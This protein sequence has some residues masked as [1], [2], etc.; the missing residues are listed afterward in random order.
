MQFEASITGKWLAMLKEIAPR[1]AR[2]ALVK[3]TKTN[4]YEH[5]MRAAEGVAPS[6]SIE[7]VSSHVEKP[8][9]IARPLSRSRACRTAA[10][11]CCAIPRPSSIAISLSRWQPGIACRQSTQVVILLSRVVSCPT[12]STASSFTARLRGRSRRAQRRQCRW[13]AS[14]AASSARD[15]PLL[16]PAFQPGSQ[17]SR[18]CGGPEMNE[19]HRP[20]LR[21]HG[22]SLLTVELLPKRLELL[23]EAIPNVTA[24]GGRLVSDQISGQGR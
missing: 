4:D 2:A 9:D 5:F 6:L 7:L 24:V 23:R 8:A 17:R 3:N 14:S 12:G 10:W 18:L 22:V 21:T 16:L 11:L 20:G 1:L 15:S 19:R 13:S